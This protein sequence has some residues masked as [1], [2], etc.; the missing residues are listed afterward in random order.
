MTHRKKAALIAL[1]AMTGGC[2]PGSGPEPDPTG[3]GSDCL[4]PGADGRRGSSFA[5]ALPEGVDPANAPL[6]RNRAEATVFRM[7]Y[8]TLVDVACDGTVTPGLAEKWSGSADGREWT[9]DLR[10][11]AWFK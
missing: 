3:H 11:D 8:E 1:V 9:F 5:V 4:P 10:R 6:P 7:L 2:R